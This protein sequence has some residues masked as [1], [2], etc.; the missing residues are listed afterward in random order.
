MIKLDNGNFISKNKQVY[1]IRCPKCG[2]ENYAINVALGICTWCG[3]NG[4]EYYK[5]KKN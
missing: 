3:L 2:K 1:L 4:N 5:T